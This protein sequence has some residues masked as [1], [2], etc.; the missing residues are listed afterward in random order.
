VGSREL[1]GT[2]RV[3]RDADVA[4][5]EETEHGFKVTFRDRSAQVDAPV[6][7]APEAAALHLDLPEEA[8]DPR[9]AIRRIH[10]KYNAGGTS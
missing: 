2:L 6:V 1:K 3:L 7:G 10:Q 5:Y 9:E 4:T 8:W